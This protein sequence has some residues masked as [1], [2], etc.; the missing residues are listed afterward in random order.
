M[1]GCEDVALAALVAT[2]ARVIRPPGPPQLP[3]RVF[4]VD[5]GM[6]VRF[7]RNVELTKALGTL[8][9]LWMILQMMWGLHRGVSPIGH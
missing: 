2:R 7:C 1:Y 9:E 5:R 3:L 4:S 8:P 6:R